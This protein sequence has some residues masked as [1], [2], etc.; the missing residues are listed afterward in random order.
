MATKLPIGGGKSPYAAF[1]RQSSAG[2]LNRSLD[3]SPC[4]SNTILAQSV[5]F[6][7]NPNATTF[8]PSRF[9]EHGYFPP[10]AYT[11]E[12]WLHILDSGMLASNP[13]LPPLLVQF[14]PWSSEKLRDLAQLFCWEILAKANIVD[15]GPEAALFARDVRD[16]FKIHHSEWVSSCFVAH[17]QKAVLEHFN[18]FWCSL[19]NPD[20]ISQRKKLETKRWNVALEI[21]CFI[22]DLFS[23]SLIDASIMHECLGI[24]LYEMVSVQ[25]VRV[26]QSMVKR[27]G[28]TLWQTA[29][30]HERRQEFIRHFM[31][32]TS[33]LP[34]NSSLTG[35]EKIIRKAIE[36]DDIIALIN[37]WHARRSEYRSPAVKSIWGS[38]GLNM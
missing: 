12:A 32:R 34:D 13:S 29:D 19:D 4:S 30:S 36:A 10:P 27:A 15:F 11:P 16:N 7:L 20:V 8:I 28:P 31:D 24:L 35:R 33:K 3:V 14:G 17:L 23:F 21:S 1:S 22:A 25:H 2:T 6:D 18:S 26:V 37:G 38:S 5:T 9:V